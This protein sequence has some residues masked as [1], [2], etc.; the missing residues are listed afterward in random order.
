MDRWANTDGWSFCRCPLWVAI[1]AEADFG[2]VIIIP[3]RFSARW[4]RDTG[5]QA[6]GE[7]FRAR[8][9]GAQFGR[10]DQHRLGRQR[11]ASLGL[12]RGTG[13]VATFLARSSSC[14]FAGAA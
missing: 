14:P 9:T 2:G 13:S 5:R 1:E 4:W 7:F 12:E 8:I 3:S 11:S 10:P 6:E